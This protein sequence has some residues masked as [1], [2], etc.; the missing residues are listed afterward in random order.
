MTTP[1]LERVARAIC[2]SMSNTTKAAEPYPACKGRN[3]GCTDGRSHSPEC[4]QDHDDAAAG[5]L[6]PMWLMGAPKEPDDE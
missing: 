2:K 1:L 3:C 4:Q 5:V 6:G